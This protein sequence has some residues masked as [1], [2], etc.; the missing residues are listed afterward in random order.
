MRA[1]GND[2]LKLSSNRGF[3]KRSDPGKIVIL[4][5][6]HLKNHSTESS[7]VDSPGIIFDLDDT[8]IDSTRAYA[9]ALAEVGIPENHAPFERAQALVKDRLGPGHVCG[10]NR[11][12]YFKA[13]LEEKG[14][15]SGQKVLE[16][17]RAYENAL[18][19]I[20]SLQW[21]DLGRA[22]L[23]EK[24]VSSFPMVVLTNENTRTQMIKFA[25]IDPFGTLFRHV[26]TSEELGFEK[27]DLRAFAAAAERLRLPLGECWVIGDSWEGDI[28]PALRL[29]CRAIWTK[30]FR[31]SK[32]V[33]T[34]GVTTVSTLNDILKCFKIQKAA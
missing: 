34:Q 27:P 16:L 28:E 2:A 22:S 21:L 12:L 1:F 20:I 9:A 15:F 19:R 23:L 14:E 5:L 26:V 4:R 6:P 8:L 13:M 31:R 29:G 32:R 17:T 10:H 11:A 24:L 7:I 30:E 25:A 3:E 33:V 18:F